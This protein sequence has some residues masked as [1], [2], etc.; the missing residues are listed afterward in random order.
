M[1]KD[2]CT[3]KGCWNHGRYAR[4]CGHL[5]GKSAKPE[6]V[7]KRSKK[8]DTLMRKDYVPQ[9]KE[10]VEAGTRCVIGSPDCTR[11]AQGFHHPHGK[12]SDELRMSDKVPCCNACNTWIEKNDAAAR[13]KGWKK[14]KFSVPAKN[15][16]I[17]HAEENQKA[18]I[19][20]SLT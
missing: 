1:T 10:M 3:V 2:L 8:L 19:D 12:A 5:S 17:G 14:S 18:T 9:V 20:F 6:P 16:K 11:T 7:A 15:Q 4:P 13:A